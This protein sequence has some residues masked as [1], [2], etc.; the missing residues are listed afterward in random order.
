MSGV[1]ENL[2]LGLIPR[3]GAP[4][5]ALLLAYLDRQRGLVAWKL[6]GLPDEV[7]RAV[8]T[9]SGLNVHGLVRH[10]EDVERSWVREHLDGQTGLTYG[11]QEGGDMP[12][13][14]D[15][16]LTD[17]LAS[18]AAE[19]RRCDE[20]LA[21]LDLDEVGATKDHTVRWVVLHL[22]EEIARHVGHLDL[23]AELADGRTGEEPA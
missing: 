14:P 13:T 12:T 15:A 18:Y 6:D 21:R 11:W 1:T 2:L 16:R 5:R 10:L 19:L 8:R 23:L 3:H 7:A 9:P 4:D 20:V 17:L 22:I